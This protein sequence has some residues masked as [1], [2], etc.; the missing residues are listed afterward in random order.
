MAKQTYLEIVNRVLRRLN[1]ADLATISDA[2]G[3]SQVCAD[4][5][6]EVQNEIYMEE[7]WHSLY[8]TSTFSTVASTA[9][10]S[11]PTD[12]GRT[13]DLIDETNNNVL[14][15][16]MI[17]HFDVADPDADETGI[18]R[19]F[20]A[21]GSNYRLYPIPSGV[22]TMRYRYWAQPATLSGDSN[23]SDLPLEVEKCII[24]KTWA[25][26][27]VYLNSFEKGDRVV[28]D[29]RRQLA[30]ARITNRRVL[31]QM[32]VFVG[33]RESRFPIEPARLPQNFPRVW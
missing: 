8:A 33:P 18:P 16:S 13:I 27:L 21:Q 29:Y 14:V 15:E 7:D 24:L 17:R 31:D 12:I 23:T 26:M 1:K 3:L 4:A 5:V 32:K 28:A 20:A 10:Y 11:M 9:T 30:K 22:Y 6:N 19:W 2:S 25:E